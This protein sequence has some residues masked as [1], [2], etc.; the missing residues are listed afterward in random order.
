MRGLAVPKTQPWK[1]LA[2]SL[3][4]NGKTLILL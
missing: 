2:I 1:S 4:E 3:T